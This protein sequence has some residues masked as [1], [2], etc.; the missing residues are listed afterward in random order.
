M[1]CNLGSKY[2]ALFSAVRTSWRFSAV[3]GVLS[4]SIVGAGGWWMVSKD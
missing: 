3:R 1:D 2:A 4:C